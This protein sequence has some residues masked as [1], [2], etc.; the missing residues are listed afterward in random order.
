MCIRDS[1]ITLHAV[2][3]NAI[4]LQVALKFGLLDRGGRLIMMLPQTAGDSILIPAPVVVGGA[5]QTPA[6]TERII[7]L[8]GTEVQ[9]FN[10]GY[11]LAYNITLATAG[12]GAVQFDATQQIRIRVWAELSYQVN[13]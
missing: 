4:P 2:V 3:D 8:S 12:T 6:H 5:V 9:Q 11:S 13:K 10:T 7:T 1:G